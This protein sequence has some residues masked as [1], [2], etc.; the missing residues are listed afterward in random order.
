MDCTSIIEPRQPPDSAL[1][2]MTTSENEGQV[3]VLTRQRPKPWKPL[4]IVT[5]I[6]VSIAIW[7]AM[8]IKD[9]LNGEKFDPLNYQ[10]RTA[11]VLSQT[12]LI[13]GHNDLPFLVRLQLNNQIYGNNLPFRQGESYLLKI[14]RNFGC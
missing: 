5:L 1:A 3:V 4:K 12:P 13:D 6:S 8:G 11:R 10:A 2:E 7:M 9:M 14:A